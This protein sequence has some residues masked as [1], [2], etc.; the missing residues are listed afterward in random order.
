MQMKREW[1]G[2]DLPECLA[3]FPA[4]FHIEFACRKL[5]GKIADSNLMIMGYH[6][7]AHKHTQT[8]MHNISI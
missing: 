5:A 3:T 7:E 4:G 6:T 1:G 2:I 8:H